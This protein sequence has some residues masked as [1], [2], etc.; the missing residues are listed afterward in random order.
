MG[1]VDLEERWVYHGSLTTPPCT[2]KV[3]WNVI[4]KIFPIR[5]KEMEKFKKLMELNKDKIGAVF[6]NRP[7]QPI[8]NQ[9]IQYIGA[10][11]LS[12]SL[13]LV[14]ASIAIAFFLM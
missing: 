3:Y 10:C 1:F 4:N 5:L 11:Y 9:G 8:L 2:P 7:L 14:S 13:A 12:N 6:N